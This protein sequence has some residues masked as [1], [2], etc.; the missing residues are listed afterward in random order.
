MYLKYSY[1]QNNYSNVDYSKPNGEKKTIATSGCGVCSVVTALNNAMGYEHY[2]I[3][4]VASFSKRHGCRDNYGT[5]VNKLLKEICSHNKRMSFKTTELGNDLVKH[6]RN[7]GIAIINQ[8]EARAKAGYP[9]FSTS[10]HYVVAYDVDDNNNVYVFDPDYTSTRYKGNWRRS[11][12]V[13]ELDGIGCVANIN[14]INRATAPISYY[15]ISYNKPEVKPKDNYGDAYSLITQ[16][17]YSDSLMKYR[18]GG[19]VAGEGVY[20][21]G[22]APNT[23]IIVFKCGDYYKT[24][25][26]KNGTIKKR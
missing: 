2:G 21:C 17:A 20:D 15:L 24:G 13:K 6:L 11:R 10:G 9:L 19:V 7:G 16:D 22:T 4:E 3:E 12:I 18:C 5:N 23:Q 1:N 25:F 26:V 8:S 14:I